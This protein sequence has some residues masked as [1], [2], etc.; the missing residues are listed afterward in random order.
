MDKNEVRDLIVD[1]I[2]ENAWIEFLDEVGDKATYRQA[3][4]EEWLGESL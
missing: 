1:K 3:E 4:I 2:N